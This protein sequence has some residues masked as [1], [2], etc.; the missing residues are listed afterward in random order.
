MPQ[1]VGTPVGAV[2][3]YVVAVRVEQAEV[4]MQSI[5]RAIAVGL[6]HEAGGETM[7]AR[8]AL[9]RA[10]EEQRIV[11]GAQRVGDMQQVDLELAGAVF[12]DHRVGG[13]I[14]RFAGGIDVGDKSLELI[15]FINR[16]DA[17]RMQALAG[18][19]RFRRRRARI[20]RIDQIKL[21][22]GGDHRGQPES[23]VTIDDGRQCAARI[24]E[25]RRTIFLGQPQ[26]D[27]CGRLGQPVYRHD[28]AS[29]P[30]ALAIGVTR[31]EH[32]F[33]VDD[34]FAPDIHAGSRQRHANSAFE[35]LLRLPDRDSLAAQITV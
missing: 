31:S 23:G 11:G 19:G 33:A 30:L 3:E 20:L 9:D 17:V 2:V 4:N 13:Y 7:L 27:K 29:G 16:Q 32:Q 25:K 21:E 18:K 24:C 8:D 15:E 1:Q 28:I 5:A 10:L 6:G 34:V 12:G 14:L 26:R 35:R 22:F